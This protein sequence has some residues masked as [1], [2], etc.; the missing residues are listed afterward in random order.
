MREKGA[1]DFIKREDNS[2]K[3]Y[4]KSNFNKDIE[5]P[6]LYH[7]VVNT[8]LTTYEEAARLIGHAVINKFHG[9]FVTKEAVL[10]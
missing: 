6:H 5:N 8:G 10:Y 3:N 4:V 7:L 9:K 2:R 1:V